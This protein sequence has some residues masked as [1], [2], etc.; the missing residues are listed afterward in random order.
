VPFAIPGDCV[1]CGLEGQPWAQFRW[2]KGRACDACTE[3][4]GG[5]RFEFES[6]RRLSYKLVDRKVIVEEVK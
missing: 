4:H 6:V 2:G 3:G 5:E 1:Y